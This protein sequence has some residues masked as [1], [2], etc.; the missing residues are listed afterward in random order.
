MK[1]TSQGQETPNKAQPQQKRGLFNFVAGVANMVPLPGLPKQ[2]TNVAQDVEYLQK[3]VN[4]ELNRI[5]LMEV[6]R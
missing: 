2:N 5:W 3:L 4:I 6:I 1:T